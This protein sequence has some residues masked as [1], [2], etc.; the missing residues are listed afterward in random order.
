MTIHVELLT[1]DAQDRVTSMATE[2]HATLEAA[3]KAARRLAGTRRQ[4][5]RVGQLL[6]VSGPRGTAYVTR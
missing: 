1:R 3:I 6:R 2:Q 4:M 5:E